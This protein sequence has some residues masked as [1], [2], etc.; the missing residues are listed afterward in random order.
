[1]G[2]ALFWEM[3][4]EEGCDVILGRDAHRPEELLDEKRE[5]MALEYLSGLGITPMDT[6]KLRKP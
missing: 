6:V 3:V 1:L 4:A 2:I 5:R